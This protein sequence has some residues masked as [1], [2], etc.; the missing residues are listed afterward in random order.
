MV[1]VYRPNHG[2]AEDQELCIV[3]RCVAGIQQ[4]AL[5]AASE[6]PIDV[7]ARA[8]DTGKWFFVHQAR[9]AVLFGD[10]SQGEHHQ[11]LVVGRKVRGFKHR[12]NLELSRRDFVVTRLDRNT[13]L[14]QLTFRLEHECQHAFRNRTKIVVIKLLALGGRAAEQC[15]PCIKQ[16]G[17]G[18]VEISVNQEIL[19]FRTGRRGHKGSLFVPE[20]F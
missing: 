6:R 7:F 11:L 1:L 15:S 8:V 12:C 20:Q 17:T 18:I 19:L 9:H 4:V 16:V 3:V 2:C 14:E 10:L 13:E 5:G